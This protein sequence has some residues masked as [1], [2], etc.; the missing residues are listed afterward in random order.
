MPNPFVFTR[1]LGPEELVDREGEV[2]QLV[3]N[4]EAGVNTRLTSPRDYGKTSLLARALWEADRHG[5]ATVRVD[6]YGARTPAQMAMMIERAYAEQLKSPLRRVFSAIRRR[7][8]GMGV[9]TPAGGG[10]LALGAATGSGE[11]ELLDLLELP[12]RLHRRDGTRFAVAFDEFQV[13]LASGKG[14]DGLMRSVIQHHGDAA[15]YVFAGSHPGMMRELFADK[16]RPFYGQ[17]APIELGPLPDEP[18]ADHI[19]DRFQRANRDPGLALDWLLDLVTGH[20]QRAM[21][22]AHL[23]YD[24]T[25]GGE[26]ASEETWAAVLETA[27]PY[28]RDDLERTWDGL[29][30]IESGVVEAAALSAKGLTARDTRARFSLPAGSGAPRAAKRLADRGLLVADSQRPT[31]YR[32]V[33]PLF[34]RWVAAGRRWI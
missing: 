16:R 21:L 8:A 22:M 32:I 13:V 5:M 18:L 19:A 33:D 26:T 1:P 34:G 2:G 20:P 17:T 29:S 31:G 27:W 11:R 12:A 24:E 10:S 4:L 3:S 15:T 7:G 6:L 23:L 28:I 9:Q 14:L 30:A 25:P